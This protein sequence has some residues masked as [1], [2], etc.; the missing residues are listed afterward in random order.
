MEENN[1]C[2]IDGQNLYIGTKL[3]DEP[4]V[5]DFKKLR[6]YLKKKYKIKD[7]YYYVGYRDI[8]NQ[9]IYSK[10]ENCNYKIIFKNHLSSM[11][12][13]KKGNIDCDIIF[14]AMKKICEKENFNKIILISGDGDYIKLVNYLIEKDKFKKI[15]FPNKKY[16]SSLYKKLGRKYFDYLYKIKLKLIKK[17]KPLEN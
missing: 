4:W 11:A 6:K 12:S 10:L 17:Q 13:K 1:L 3:E 15:L 16:A 5:I 2:F 8:L 7:V 14:D 9:N